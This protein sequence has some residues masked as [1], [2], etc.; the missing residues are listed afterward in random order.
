M[1]LNP[2]S[3][4]S[5]LKRVFDRIKHLCSFGAA[6]LTVAGVTEKSEARSDSVH[7]SMSDSTYEMESTYFIVGDIC[8]E[9]MTTEERL[10]DE[11]EEMA[12]RKAISFIRNIFN[13]DKESVQRNCKSKPETNGAE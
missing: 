11:R 10:W 3:K 8:H 12:N 2:K 4:Q 5:L 6:L 1:K 9:P 7:T 13:V